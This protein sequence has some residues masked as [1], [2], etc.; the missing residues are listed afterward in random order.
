MNILQLRCPSCSQLIETTD[1]MSGQVIS[2]PACSGDLQIPVIVENQTTSRKALPDA[3]QE[4]ATESI[5]PAS[6]LA[7]G[8]PETELSGF[9]IK[10]GLSRSDHFTSQDEETTKPPKPPVPQSQAPPMHQGPERRNAPGSVSSLVLG[11]ISIPLAL[12]GGFFVM[13]ILLFSGGRDDEFIVFHFA[14]LVVGTL[15]IAMAAKAKRAIASS[16][17]HYNGGG[18]AMAG[19]TCGIIGIVI[20][21]LFLVPMLSAM[22]SVTY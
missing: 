5:T 10:K 15:A 19:M 22:L 8:S 9:E 1:S 2:C 7:Q 18:K 17:G 11:I 4:A 14:S 12:V 20:F 6:T 13:L 21:V 3:G 16:A